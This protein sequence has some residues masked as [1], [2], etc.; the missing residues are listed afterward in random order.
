MAHLAAGAGFAFAVEME[1]DATF[2]DEFGPALDV[3]ADEVLHHRVAAGE[4]G[5]AR[6]Q[7]ANGADVLLELRGDRALDGPVAAVVDAGR[8]LVDDGAVGAGEEFDGEDAD[9]AESLGDG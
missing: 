5:D 3:A 8:D 1:V 9:M 4:A 7:A 2:G 6:R